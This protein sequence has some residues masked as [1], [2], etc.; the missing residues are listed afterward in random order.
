MLKPI[1]AKKLL[2]LGDFAWQQQLFSYVISME[3]LTGYN[4][5]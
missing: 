5:A 4:L 3:T 2:Q 1:F